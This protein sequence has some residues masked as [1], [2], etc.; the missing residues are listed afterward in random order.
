MS[1]RFVFI[2]DEFDPSEGA[3]TLATLA[4]DDA[5]MT[6]ETAIWAPELTGAL[7]FPA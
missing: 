3:S 5:P 6:L 2:L 4:D 1:S 7:G